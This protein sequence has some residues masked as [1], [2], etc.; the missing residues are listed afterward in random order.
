VLSTVNAMS[1]LTVLDMQL[2]HVKEFTIDGMGMHSLLDL[3]IGE[4]GALFVVSNLKNLTTL[5]ICK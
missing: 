2:P 1:K 5:N 3:E 4:R